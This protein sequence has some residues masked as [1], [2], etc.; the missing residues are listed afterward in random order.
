LISRS[1]AAAGSEWKVFSGLSR[2][3]AL[4]GKDEEEAQVPVF[5]LHPSS[6]ILHPSSFIPSKKWR[7][8]FK[9]AV[10]NSLEAAGL[11]DVSSSTPAV[12]ALVPIL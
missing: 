6:L 12:C 3:A 4:A 8:V 9:L 11:A 1:K 7:S 10:S 2:F 5:I